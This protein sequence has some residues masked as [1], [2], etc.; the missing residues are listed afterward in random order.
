MKTKSIQLFALVFAML[1]TFA[2]DVNAQNKTKRERPQ[3]VISVSDNAIEV[4]QFH[5]EHRCK[6][7]IS[8]EN[9]AKATLG[10]LSN[11]QFKTVNV[12]EK[13]NADIVMKF[14]AFGSSLFL[15]N[16]NTGKMKDLTDFAFMNAF[17]AEKF[18]NGLNKAITEFSK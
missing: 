7:C 4:I 12:D 5:N 10:K 2:L 9:N 8:I 17:D 3:P 15:Y 1:F 18:E 13:A 14:K 16:K 11:I 6:T